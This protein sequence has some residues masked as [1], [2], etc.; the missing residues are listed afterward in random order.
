MCF[1]RATFKP[2][3]RVTFSNARC[4]PGSSDVIFYTSAT[5][6]ISNCQIDSI[7]AP[8]KASRCQ[9]QQTSQFEA[10]VQNRQPPRCQ[11]ITA[12]RLSNYQP[13]SCAIWGSDWG[14]HTLC[15]SADDRDRGRSDEFT[16]DG[17]SI[18]N[19]LLQLSYNCLII[20]FN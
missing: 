12:C 4:S 3:P 6:T 15:A 7:E 9:L 1:K 13:R 8:A 19:R 5:R 16:D 20:R 2:P 18:V 14:L 10:Q 11:K 17:C